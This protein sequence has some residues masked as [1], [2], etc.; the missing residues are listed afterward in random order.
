MRR[1]CLVILVLGMAG[2]VS[3]ATPPG[4]Y[5]PVNGLD[6]YYEIHGSAGGTPLL[7]LHGGMSSIDDS[8]GK[9]LPELAKRRRVIAVE[10]QGHGHTADVDRPFSYEQMADDTAALLVYLKEGKVDCFGWSDGGIVALQLA[11]RHPQSVRKIVASGPSYR[12]DGMSPEAVEWIRNATVESWPAEIRAI[13]E[14][15]APDPKAWPAYTVKI[16]ALWLGQDWPEAELRSIRAPVLLMYG[17]HDLISTEHGV[18]M[19]R[20]IADSQL[21]VLPDTGHATLFEQPDWVLT[22]TFRFLDA[23]K[24]AKN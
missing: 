22:M 9:L 10:Q 5:A 24:A 6:M 19:Q 12:A 4:H 3:A 8:F 16:R 20:L 13:Y 21:A 18:R 17:D 2:S 1:I 11:S 15:A 14:K 7:L 23:P